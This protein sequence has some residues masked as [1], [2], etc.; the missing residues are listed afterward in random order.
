LNSLSASRPLPA[1]DSLAASLLGATHAV[2]A[3]LAG[4][5]LD[6]AFQRTPDALTGNPAAVRDL[7]YQCLRAHAA[8]E[9]RLAVLV[10]K[11]L[12]EADRRALLLVALCRLTA[13][14][15]GAHTTVNQAV[16]AARTL[17]GDRF[18]A[19]MNA[20]LRNAQRRA[21][22]LDNAVAND[23]AAH[24]QHPGWWLERLQRDHPGHWQ[25]IAAQGNTHP[26]MALRVNIRR[27]T[28]EHALAR[29]KEVGIDAVA[30]GDCGILLNRPAP[31]ARLPGFA[32]GELS[33]QDLGAQ[34]A[35][36]LLDAQPGMR[37]LD[38]C[39]APGGKASHLLEC[40]DVD[41]LALDLGAQRAQRIGENF[42]RLGLK[43]TIEVGDAGKPDTWWDGRAF[44]RILADV[45]CSASGV[46][47]RHP[48]AKWL[49]RPADI[50]SFGRQQR[51]LLDALWRVLAPG[52]KLLY[53]TC[54]VFRAE[55]EDQVASFV[56]RH[57]DCL[58]LSPCGAPDLQLLPT[59]E[60]DGFYYALLQKRADTD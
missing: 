7:A 20:V 30:R 23:T 54:S 46:V 37:V 40:A 36:A 34:R 8:I 29:L 27:S 2:A 38:A 25:E 16:D 43:A 12:R 45:P 11:P 4:N 15:E 5:A 22:E 21:A 26:P 17:G 39:A 28:V 44:D 1:S 55:N 42:E 57:S 60:H 31:V 6:E 41:L 33:V 52:G 32:A 51:V 24:W 3:V 10:P 56:D 53:A 47:R 49:R 35:A 9:S 50:A 14:A 19:L 59:A 13:R 48:D 18:A 58:R